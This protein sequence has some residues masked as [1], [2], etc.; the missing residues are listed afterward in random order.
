MNIS[1]FSAEALNAVET[2][3]YNEGQKNPYEGQ[4]GQKKL[5]EQNKQPR[6]P[7]QER[8]DQARSQALRGK[9]A[10]SGNRTESAKKAAATRRQ[11]KGLP[12][13][14]ETGVK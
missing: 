9:S 1:G 8:A 4:C 11:C 14:P 3:L 10:A 12:S 6:S 5:R 13:Q 2:L 7:E